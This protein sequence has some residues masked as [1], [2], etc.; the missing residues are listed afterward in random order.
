MAL[1]SALLHRCPMLLIG[2]GVRIPLVF[3]CPHTG[4]CVVEGKQEEG[5]VKRVDPEGEGDVG[6]RWKRR[7]REGRAIGAAATDEATTKREGKGVFMTW[8]SSTLYVCVCV[9][10][11][12]FPKEETCS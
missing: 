3:S 10:V 1:G 6:E 9:C 11:R 12:V 2:G 5:E 4:T 7:R 8:L